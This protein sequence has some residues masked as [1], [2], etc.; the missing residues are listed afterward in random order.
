MRVFW[1]SRPINFLPEFELVQDFMPV[2]VICNFHKDPIKTKQAMLWTRSN[3][4]VVKVTPKSRVLSGQNL[5]SSKISC[6]SRL[7]ARLIKI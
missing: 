4:G 3:T 2:Q 1:H 5:N 6:L 7:S